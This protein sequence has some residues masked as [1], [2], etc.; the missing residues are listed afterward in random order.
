MHENIRKGC[1]TYDGLRLANDYIQDLKMIKD[2]E[3]I[4]MAEQKWLKGRWVFP[5]LELVSRERKSTSKLGKGKM[6]C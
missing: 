5:G 3:H 1:S 4:K 6:W 2:D